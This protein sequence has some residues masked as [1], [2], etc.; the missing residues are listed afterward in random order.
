MNG[1]SSDPL[2]RA[3]RACMSLEGLSLGDAFGE[4]F[5]SKDAWRWQKELTF[6]PGPWNYTDD[7]EMALGLFD[8]LIRNGRVDQDR[9]AKIFAERFHRDPWKGYGGTVRSVLRGIHDGV[10]WRTLAPLAYSGEG[11]MGNGSAMRVGVLGAWFADDP[12]RLVHEA[13]LSAEVT[14]SHKDGQA[15]AIAVAVATSLM[16]RLK[17]FDAKEFFSTIL[18]T[19][20]AGYTHDGIA[21]AAELPS[22]YTIASAV[23]ALGNG[24]YLTCSDTIPFCLWVIGRHGSDF[25]EAMWTAVSAEGD[26]DTTCAII[27][28]I[29]GCWGGRPNL[30][31]SWIRLREPLQFDVDKRP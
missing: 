9:L 19:T 24:N 3:D 22:G 10:P 1:L 8:C 12:E 18:A 15:G 11:S 16:W 4:R 31:E 13:R 25:Q 5:F 14:H 27:G 28:S 21:R 23:I 20:P 7:T 17:P 2:D 6:P 30:P 26:R 29:I